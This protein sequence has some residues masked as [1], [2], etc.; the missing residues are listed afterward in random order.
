[1]FKRKGKVKSYRFYQKRSKKKKGGRFLDLGIAL[2]GILTILFV[3]SSV[4]RLT[5]TQAEG[6]LRTTPLR[7][8]VL[9]ASG[10]KLNPEI[11]KLIE[12]KDLSPYY[13]KVVEQKDFSDSLVKES[14]LLD[15]MGG[16]GIS[17]QVAEKLGLK[18]E[19]ILLEKLEGN[20][21]NISYTLILGQDYQKLLKLNDQ[22]EE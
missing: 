12:E 8:Q 3:L 1:M 14:L 5:Q 13:L 22:K 17:K 4:K 21:L 15:R 6:S 20:Y 10:Q 18:R 2:L 16:K 7:I 9:N 11:I 19:N